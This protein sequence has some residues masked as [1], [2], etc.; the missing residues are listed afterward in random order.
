LRLHDREATRRA[1]E[2]FALVPTSVMNFAEGTRFTWH[3]HRIQDSP[4]RHLLKPKAG[5]LALALNAMGGEVQFA[6]RCHHRVSRWRADVLAVS[7]R[8]DAARGR[9][10]SAGRDPERVLHG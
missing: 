8:P 9:A 10:R 3:K 1:C 5:A 6:D 7:L 4:Y 2:K